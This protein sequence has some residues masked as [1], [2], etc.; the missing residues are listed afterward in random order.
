MPA[1]M[2]SAWRTRGFVPSMI[3]EVS[4]CG[5]A[6]VCMNI[7]FSYCSCMSIKH[8]HNMDRIIDYDVSDSTRSP[9][10]A[11]GKS[12]WIYQSCFWLQLG[13]VFFE[14]EFKMRRIIVLF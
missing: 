2:G 10:Q 8:S 6:C 13:G 3:Y 1:L 11:E 5:K 4:V 14:M 12:K 7:H 9:F